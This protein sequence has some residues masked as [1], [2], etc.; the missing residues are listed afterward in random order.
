M[1]TG[2]QTPASAAVFNLPNQLTVSRL[3]LA[4]VLFALMAWECY[5]TALVV[6]VVAAFT[7]WLD[8]YLARRYGM[9]TTLGRIL[10]PF[11]DKMIIC[12]VLVFL[13]SVPEPGLRELGMRAWVA[14]LV[15]GRELLVTALRGFLEQ[16]GADFS[17]AMS[18]K[19]KMVAQCAAAASSLGW[20]SL[21]QRG[22][23]PSWLSWTVTLSIWATV[24][25]TIFSG[26]AYIRTALRL[27]RA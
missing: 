8:G 9:V 20:L 24:V 5:S 4:V 23:V 14:V 27:V 1:A 13:A 21:A 10:D 26:V 22:D 2:T 25:L 17:A 15:I 19:L 6:F 11:A 18:G 7:D 16:Q 12:G 3:L